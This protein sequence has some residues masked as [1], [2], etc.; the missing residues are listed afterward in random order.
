MRMGQALNVLFNFDVLTPR[1]WDQTQPIAAVSDLLL[2]VVRDV[3]QTCL[4]G[5]GEAS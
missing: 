4:A 1:K 5:L 2:S 3:Q